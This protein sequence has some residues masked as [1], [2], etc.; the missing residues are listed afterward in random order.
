MK[1]FLNIDIF[2]QAQSDRKT[3]HSLFEAIWNYYYGRLT[4]FVQKSCGTDPEDIVQEILLKVYDNLDKYKPFYSFNTWIY[5]I[6]RNYCINQYRKKKIDQRPLEETAPYD[7]P[8]DEK[9][10]PESLYIAHEETAR[11]EEIL[12]QMEPDLYQIA[13]LRFFE[14]LKYR[15]IARIEQ[16]PVGTIKAQEKNHREFRVHPALFF[17]E[18]YFF[19]SY[20]SGNN[21]QKGINFKTSEGIMRFK[22]FLSILLFGLA[23]CLS[24]Q[25]DFVFGIKPGNTVNSAYFG[26]KMDNLVPMVGVDVVWLTAS[27]KYTDTSEDQWNS[28]YDGTNYKQKTVSSIDMEGS[29][30]LLIPHIGAKYFLGS[31]DVKPYF[32]GNAFFSMPS[33][34]ME[35]SWKD[36]SWYYEDNRQVDHDTDKGSEDLDEETEDIIKDV[37]GFWGITIGGG[38]EYFF[39]ERFS[40]GGEYGIRLL[41]NSVN[42]SGESGDSDP[43]GYGQSYRNEWEGELSASLRV[44]Y[45]VVSLN[46]YF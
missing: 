31:G 5:T 41:F 10:N 20:F 21:L 37:L 32:F 11:I 3:R 14:K 35:S 13:F 2:L 17:L 23:T 18:L 26:L 33:V 7:L 22:L 27:G 16:K 28:Y 43:N 4:V 24:A 8:Q 38:A 6:A 25:S 29:A 40:I 12:R 1:F 36:E 45:A 30:L 46:F 9:N 34:K 15:E 44:T 42:I 19:I 39:S